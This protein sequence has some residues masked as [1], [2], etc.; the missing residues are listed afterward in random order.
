[1]NTHNKSSNKSIINDLKTN[2][3]NTARKRYFAYSIFVLFIT[4]C[5]ICFFPYVM[6]YYVSQPD[7]N[8]F[9]YII[10][11]YLN[12]KSY[13]T[14]E[15]KLLLFLIVIILSITSRLY[16]SIAVTSSLGLI[17]AYASHLKYINRMEML[18]YTDLKLTEAATMAVNYLS[19]EFNSYTVFSLLFVILFIF[20]STL[21][22]KLIADDIKK[23]KLSKL[24]LVIQPV[25]FLAAVI[26]LFMYHTSFM[27]NEFSRNPVS[28]YLYFSDN[29]NK[30]VLYQFLQYSQS[31]T[32]ATEV[33]ENYIKLT[34]KLISENNISITKKD[35]STDEKPTIIV[36]MNESWW[37]LD[38]I[39]SDVVSYSVNPMKPLA[40][41][42]D[43]CDIGSVGVNIYGGGTVSSEA[44]FFTGLN[45]KYFSST[46]DIYNTLENRNFPSVVQYFN[47][48]GYN[49][50]AIHP[51][52]GHFYN[53]ENMFPAIGFDNSIFEDSM[54]YT[55]IFDKYISDEALVN[56][57]IYECE[58]N[59]DAPNFIFAISIASHSLNLNYNQNSGIDYPYK[60]DVSFAD[61]INLSDEEYKNF[62]HHV[63]SIYE[64]NLAY[65]KLINYF[66]Q[67]ESPVMVVMYGDHCFGIPSP[68][69]EYMGLNEDGQIKSDK[70]TD[71]AN[72]ANILYSTP[73]AAWSNFSK[74]PFDMN[75]EN[76]NAL[77]DKIID[78]AGLPPT[79]MMLINK[80]LR[81]YIKADTRSY[82]LD[83][84]G[85]TLT[86]LTSQQNQAI[87][88]FLMIQHDILM[89]EL[90]C[91][92]IWDPL[93]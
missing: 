21:P 18:N 3:F 20:L 50:T 36:I 55:D 14:Y 76:I 25:L 54:T 62:V 86:K 93:E 61:D 80:H 27:T 79:R 11:R 16:I 6:E 26:A 48:L 5:F 87:E 17:L 83:S 39:P 38:N 69:L 9:S 13:A 65:A 52:Y 92:D 47:K 57:I 56:Q 24:R 45:T 30:H 81:Q 84:E 7:E 74:E 77:C 85:N 2:Y 23:L 58:T 4:F 68:L 67:K 12:P 91:G 28:R 31:N 15:I 34:N 70:T 32:S 49:T 40:D 60:V 37:N 73:V 89:G 51:Y 46:V 59:T 88:E 44:E 66:E 10:Q 90:I 8:I 71:T 1:M 29:S 53:R 75:G 63:N 33:K 78:Y 42:A 41:L 72:K 82:I 35:T 19:L 22:M 43:K 64:S